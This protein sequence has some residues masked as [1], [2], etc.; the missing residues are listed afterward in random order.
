MLLS[1]FR[2]SKTKQW[3]GHGPAEAVK[4]GQGSS[5]QSSDT[6]NN[7]FVNLLISDQQNTNDGQVMAQQLDLNL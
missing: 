7:T 5:K 3:S 6:E 4:L 1:Y 2:P